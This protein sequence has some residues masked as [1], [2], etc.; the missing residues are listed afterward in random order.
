MIDPIL[1]LK[2]V[3]A[4][5]FRYIS[6]FN[7][8]FLVSCMIT[9]PAFSSL[10]FQKLLYLSSIWLIVLFSYILKPSSKLLLLSIIIEILIL[11]LRFDIAVIV[12]VVGVVVVN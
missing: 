11:V 10:M 12:V 2:S 8:K 9:L 3:E 4:S 7:S 5:F 1:F 6:N